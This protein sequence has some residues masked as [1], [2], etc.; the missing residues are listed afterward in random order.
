MSGAERLGRYAVGV[1]ASLLVLSPLLPGVKDSFP[2]ST[3]PMFARARGELTLQTLSGVRSD[4]SELPLG[5]EIVGSDEVL[6]AKAL[7]ADSVARGRA[8]L[9]PLCESSATRV[10]SEPALGE[11][12]RVEIVQKRFD[13]LA[14]FV[15]SPSPLE[16]NLLWSCAVRRPGRRR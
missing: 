9:A 4:G 7:I 6:Q 8:G 15:V 11:V 1:G 10:A 12:E 14:Y 5:P 16:R 13:P 3:Y 2:L